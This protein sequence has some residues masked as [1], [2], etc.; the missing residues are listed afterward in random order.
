LIKLEIHVAIAGPHVGGCWPPKINSLLVNW[1]QEFSAI[2]SK[3]TLQLQI[4]FLLLE[5]IESGT[6]P[7]SKELVLGGNKRN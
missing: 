1:R 3:L 6:A 4:P 2:W 7:V 5:L